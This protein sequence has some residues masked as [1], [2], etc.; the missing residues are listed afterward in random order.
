[1][2]FSYSVS[3]SIPFFKYPHTT[4]SFFKPLVPPSL[5]LYSP[6]TF[7]F[8]INEDRLEPSLL[9]LSLF[10][11]P[12]QALPT[13]PLIEIQIHLVCIIPRA[14]LTPTA[15]T[16]RPPALKFVLSTGC[17]FHVYHN[18]V[19]FAIAFVD[20]PTETDTK[21]SNLNFP[22]SGLWFIGAFGGGGGVVPR[23]HGGQMRLSGRREEGVLKK[24]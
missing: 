9:T 3:P 12:S 8:P 10:Q 16:C 22:K 20:P 13:P 17:P 23:T 24:A 11:H 7:L 2:P 19:F 1:L 18:L 21:S 6:T 15:P 4:H 14:A 5:M